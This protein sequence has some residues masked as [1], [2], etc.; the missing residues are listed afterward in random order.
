[1]M[2]DNQAKVSVPAAH[3]NG[4]IPAPGIAVP[5]QNTP[6]LGNEPVAA[7]VAAQVVAEAAVTAQA[8][9]DI[10]SLAAT[11]VTAKATQTAEAA[12]TVAAEAAA[13]IVADAGEVAEAMVMAASAAARTAEKVRQAVADAIST[14]AAAKLAMAQSA[15]QLSEELERRKQSE[16][17]QM[18]HE[19]ELTA[20]VG[21]VA[22]DLKAPLRAVGGFTKMLRKDLANIPAE[23]LNESHFDRMD[24][25]VNA[26]ERMAALIDNL[27]SFATS[28]DR[29]LRLQTVDLE[30]LV[31]DILVHDVSPTTEEAE[32][33]PT[34]VVAP[35]L[36][37]EADAMM[38][39]QLMENL[40]GN[41]LKYTVPEQ[42]AYVQISARSENEGMV[43]VEVVDHGVGVPAG[44]HERV[45]TALHRAH[46]GYSGTGLGLAICQRIVDRLGGTIGVTDNPGGGSHFYFTLPAAVGT[47]QRNPVTPAGTTPV[48]VGAADGVSVGLRIGSS[49]KTASMGAA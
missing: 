13:D 3:P 37:V 14:E 5:T 21:I 35:L 34:V 29:P 40:I 1:M 23:G 25:I 27:L 36:Q 7:E 44:E 19:A 6:V 38:C 32:L 10:A 41:A 16:A 11:N 30:T 39:R 45:F 47:A 22:H 20:F 17:R 24:Q 43:R 18:E 15:E 9:V 26:V 12:M 31:R 48:L 2:T 46:A 28:R 49:T 4:V 33:T 42:A 8:M